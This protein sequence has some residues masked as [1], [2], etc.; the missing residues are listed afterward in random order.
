MCTSLL[1]KYLSPI[2][3]PTSPFNILWQIETLC[4]AT[5]HKSLKKWSSKIASLVVPNWA[6]YW[7]VCNWVSKLC[8][9]KMPSFNK[10]IHGISASPSL[11]EEFL[12]HLGVDSIHPRRNSLESSWN[13]CEPCVIG[14]QWQTVQSF[15]LQLIHIIC[16]CI[17]FFHYLFY[18]F[19]IYIIN[20]LHNFDW[21]PF[22]LPSFHLALDIVQVAS[23][24]T[25]LWPFARWDFGPERCLPREKKGKTWRHKNL[26]TFSWCFYGNLKKCD[27]D[28]TIF[29]FAM[30]PITK[31]SWLDVKDVKLP[32]LRGS[33]P[34][35]RSH[36]FK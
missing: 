35:E 10:K 4:T 26:R 22:S 9:W 14:D 1:K 17:Y 19:N 32:Q 30:S 13:S 31:K 8:T 11:P 28:L 21:I 2:T 29:A 33:C 6:A 23:N 3:C 16:I 5:G 20:R 24:G 12:K 25:V 36:S 18:I 34:M 15:L 27:G 7:V